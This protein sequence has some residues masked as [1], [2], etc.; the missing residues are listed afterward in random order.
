MKKAPLPLKSMIFHKPMFKVFLEEKET[1]LNYRE[2]VLFDR[3]SLLSRRDG[4]AVESFDSLYKEWWLNGV[5]HRLDGPAID[6][7]NYVDTPELMGDASYYVAG[8]EFS[9]TWFWE[10]IKHIK[11]MPLELRATDPREWVRNF[12]ETK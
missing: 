4:P 11:D 2:W 5:R 9:R 6:N 10:L 12:K 7:L 1:H 8:E 3:H